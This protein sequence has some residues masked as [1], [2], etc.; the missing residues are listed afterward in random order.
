M[1]RTPS[2]FM[3][4][5]GSWSD[6]GE[7]Q[8]VLAESG[9]IVRDMGESLAS[10]E[11]A[12]DLV[13][14]EGLADAFRF[15]RM[16]RLDE[17][18]V[19]EVQ[20]CRSAAVIEI[21]GLLQD[22]ASQLASMGRALRRSG[23]VAVRMESSG[24][25]SDWQ[26][27][28]TNMDSGAAQDLYEAS[29][30]VVSDNDGTVFTCGMHVFDLPDAQIRMADSRKAADW[31]HVFC[32][33]Q[34]AEQP[35]LASGHTFQPDAKSNRRTFE[36]WPDHRH[37]PDDGRHNP[38]GL[39]RFLAEGNAGLEASDPAPYVMPSLVAML[40]SAEK[41]KGSPLSESEV[42]SLVENAPA[43]MIEQEKIRELERARGYADIEPERAWDQWQLVRETF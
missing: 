5:P 17:R 37:H 1:A 33:Y 22:A 41:Q 12:V 6:L 13:G 31:L 38:F 42:A 2:F 39:W 7:V 14:A 27:W 10:G 30:L 28:L 4:V 23:G 36:R 35:V 43:M 24:C 16:G 25:A 11:S 8:K 19:A 29:V 26:S 34:L 20:A 40:V 21:A 3:L 9:L 15:G 32:V 18:V